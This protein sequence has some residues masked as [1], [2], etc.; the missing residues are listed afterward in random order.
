MH[1]F[2]NRVVEVS[3]LL[4]FICVYFIFEVFIIYLMKLKLPFIIPVMWEKGRYRNRHL[5][6]INGEQPSNRVGDLINKDFHNVREFYLL[7]VTLNPHSRFI[8][9]KSIF[10]SDFAPILVHILIH[11]RTGENPHHIF[12]S[13][14]LK[15]LF[16]LIVTKLV[17]SLLKF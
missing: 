16:I 13:S 17:L 4:L 5:P 10:V 15:C 11:G 12:P 14:F 2:W 1:P 8:W 3:I 7:I 9:G 6:Q